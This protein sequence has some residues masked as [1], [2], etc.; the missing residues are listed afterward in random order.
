[1]HTSSI[2]QHNPLA[3]RLSNTSRA[4]FFFRESLKQG[5]L[6]SALHYPLL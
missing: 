3:V 1:M 4:V 5:L 2:T 6:P